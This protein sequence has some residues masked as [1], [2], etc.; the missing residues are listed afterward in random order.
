MREHYSESEKQP[1]ST[2][3]E[4]FEHTNKQIEHTNSIM[5]RTFAKFR[6]YD[7]LCWPLIHSFVCGARGAWPFFEFFEFF[8][9]RLFAQFLV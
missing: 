1:K 4:T 2:M 9:G 6:F 3:V 5:V 8:P 7:G